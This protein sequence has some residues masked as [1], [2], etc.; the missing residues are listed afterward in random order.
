MV[1]T[2][3][4]KQPTIDFLKLVAS[5]LELPPEDYVERWYKGLGGNF[6]KTLRQVQILVRSTSWS[7]T[8]LEEIPAHNNMVKAEIENFLRKKPT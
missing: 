1:L 8:K 6:C 7:K 4:K 3:T 2:P 5:N